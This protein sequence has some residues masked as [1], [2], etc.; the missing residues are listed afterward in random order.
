[1]RSESPSGRERKNTWRFLL[2]A[3][4]VMLLAA[5]GAALYS[6]WNLVCIGTAYK[7]KILCS[8][9]FVSG[10][11]PDSI[12][13][14][15]LAVDDLWP[16]R[17][18]SAKVD[19]RRRSVTAYFAGFA[20]RSAI[21]REGLGCTLAIGKSERDIRLQPVPRVPVPPRQ[22][23][24]WP[25][26][27]E[28]A[29]DRVPAEVDRSRLRQAVN[30]AF[31][32]PDPERLRRTRAVVVVYRG[33][34]VA[35][36]YAPGFSADVPLMGWSLAKSVMNALV[37][38]AVGQGKLSL[39]DTVSAPAWT[40]V[41]DPRRKIRVQHLLHMASGLDF[42]EDYRNPLADVTY[43]L[44]GTGDVAA[45]AAEK[46]RRAAPGTLW[47]YSSGDTNL[48]SWA[49]RDALADDRAYLAFPRRALFYRI[50]MA[51]AVMEPDAAGT[52]VGSSFMYATARDWARF[53]LLYLQ[54]GVWEG[55]RI[56]P[57]GWVAYSR[58]PAPQD[59]LGNYG[60]H[61][62][63]N[64]SGEDRRRSS[65]VPSDTFYAAG[66][67]GQFVTIVPSRDL[68]VVRLGLTRAAGALDQDDLVAHVL[69][70]VGAYPGHSA[71]SP[72]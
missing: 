43:M 67:E 48:L 42:R 60:A 8:G 14:E 22:P 21:F 29:A 56:L 4:S 50:G 61:F 45:Y 54:D 5:S 27:E 65:K 59:P 51:S 12:E 16:L 69:E 9:V 71:S 55:D 23:G 11:E 24:E 36:R 30:A 64:G 66:H 34:I 31:A 72:R 33:R 57:E 41:G 13:S 20:A 32:E 62:W 37:G 7:A 53:G 47:Y 38:V 52:L 3:A 49:L 44:L 26:G 25:D 17:W 58:T 39:A 2:G 1:M 68:V 63:L 35:E 46:R 18:I 70:A 28:V 10:R 15:D 19:L 6:A 40:E